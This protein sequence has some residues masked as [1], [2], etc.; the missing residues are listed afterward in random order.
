MVRTAFIAC[1]FAR[2]LASSYDPPMGGLKEEAKLFEGESMTKEDLILRVHERTGYA[3]VETAELAEEV[4]EIIKEALA[5][6]DDVLLSGFGK[7][8][9]NS[10]TE[11]KGRNPATGEEI[12]ISARRVL[13]FTP[14]RRLR[15]SL[16][17]EP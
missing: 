13:T 4:L 3:K 6:G 9:V 12:R 1:P 5:R 14:S 7:F 8:K 11:R 17:L 15:E 2:R 10:K 16:K